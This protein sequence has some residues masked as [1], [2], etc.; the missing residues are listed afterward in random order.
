MNVQGVLDTVFAGICAIAAVANGIAWA[1]R[2]MPPFK[3]G[4]STI[5]LS[6]IGIGLILTTWITHKPIVKTVTKTV[7]VQV[8]TSCDSALVPPSA[9][10][11]PEGPV[12]IKRGGIMQGP[13]IVHGCDGRVVDVLPNRHSRI[14]P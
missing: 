4:W 1:A 11:F 9:E 2:K 7:T 6:V 8:H 13:I 14:A 3:G 12:W 5:L 10:W